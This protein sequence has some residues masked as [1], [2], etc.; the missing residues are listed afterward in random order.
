M[1]VLILA[2]FY[3][4]FI[5]ELVEAQSRYVDEIHVLIHYNP[6]VEI[7]NYVPFGGYF[8]HL[9]FYTKRNIVDLEGK[10]ENVHIHLI[11]KI[12]FIPVRTLKLVRFCLMG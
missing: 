2:P 5:K 12:Y 3:R 9:R 8:N 1:K 4:W 7:A 6:L 10:P 11:K